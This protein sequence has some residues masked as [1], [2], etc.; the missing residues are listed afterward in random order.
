MSACASAHALISCFIPRWITQVD[1]LRIM[2]FEEHSNPKFGN[3]QGGVIR[4]CLTLIALTMLSLC[5]VPIAAQAQF[6]EPFVDDFYGG[7]RNTS[8]MNT[9]WGRQWMHEL[10]RGTAIENLRKMMLVE[11]EALINLR[12]RQANAWSQIEL[13]AMKR[14]ELQQRKTERHRRR[15]I[16]KLCRTRNILRSLA[17][18]VN[19]GSYLSPI[20]TGI[21]YCRDTAE[22]ER[23]L[24]MSVPPLAADS[25]RLPARLKLGIFTSKGDLQ[26][27]PLVLVGS[28]P[29]GKM[30]T[31]CKNFSRRLGVALSHLKV[32]GSLSSADVR[33]LRAAINQWRC[34]LNCLHA[35]SE[36]DRNKAK[37]YLR[38]CDRLM[39]ILC[40]SGG[41]V[42][43]RDHLLG[44]EF[45]GGTVESLLAFMKEKHLIARNGSVA[46]SVIRK[47]ASEVASQ[48]TSQIEQLEQDYT[49][50][51][52]KSIAHR[53]NLP[54]WM[55]QER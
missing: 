44:F 27:P 4:K 23:I 49:E 24:M 48:L 51:R 29:D 34:E 14:S 38:R 15:T 46:H 55:L 45:G 35:C 39:M 12:H 11:R 19:G 40:D 52:S 31:A 47:L 42:L 32:E 37:A 3:K 54:N 26:R 2:N 10:A 17:G 20:S 43:V 8:G 22:T 7:G 21:G 33:Q 50:L 9:Y 5:A 13:N 16:E 1:G 6:D 41:S 18:G 53:A 28:Q 30:V 25:F 36:R